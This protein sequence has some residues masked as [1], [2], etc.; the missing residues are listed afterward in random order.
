[1]W[2]PVQ[3]MGV[4]PKHNKGC[5]VARCKH[6]MCVTLDGHI[7]LYGGRSANLPLKDLWRFDAGQNQ[8][9]EVH[10]RGQLPPNLQEH[11]MTA[12]NNKLYVFGGEIGFSSNGETPLWILDLST[13]TWRKTTCNP[14]PSASPATAPTG[15]RGHSAVLY[16]DAMHVYGGY[17]DLRGSSSELWTFDFSAALSLFSEQKLRHLY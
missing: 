15:R 10:C 12:W 9:E 4:S 5:P 11:T 16:G 17:Q 6:A 7:Y 13:T 8:W 1:M 2:S 14:M 3:A